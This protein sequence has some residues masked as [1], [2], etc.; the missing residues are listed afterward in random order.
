MVAKTARIMVI[1]T[2]DVV[3][4]GSADGCKLSTWRG[5]QKP[6]LRYDQSKNLAQGHSRF[7]AK[8][9]LFTIEL[10]KTVQASGN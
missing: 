8:L 5:C 1:F 3:G 7:A 10:Y 6:T 9:A 2:M 4:N